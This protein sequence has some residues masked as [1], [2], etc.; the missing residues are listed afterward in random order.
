[1]PL[2]RMLEFSFKQGKLIFCAY[3]TLSLHFLSHKKTKA[4]SLKVRP[5][6]G[7][8]SDTFLRALG[9]NYQTLYS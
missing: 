9:K 1:M 4:F 7:R 3:Q 8:A 5:I 2:I 6:V